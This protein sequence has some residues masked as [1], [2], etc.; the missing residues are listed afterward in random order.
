MLFQGEKESQP[1]AKRNIITQTAVVFHLDIYNF[2]CSLLAATSP[3]GVW[4]CS[5]E[6]NTGQIRLL[7][8]Y[9]HHA[10]SCHKSTFHVNATLFVTKN[11]HHYFR[12]DRSY[13]RYS[14]LARELL[15]I[16]TEWHVP[17]NWVLFPLIGNA[18]FSLYWQGKKIILMSYLNKEY[19]CIAFL[20]V[21]IS[22]RG[23]KNMT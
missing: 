3:G 20:K 23:D 14:K 10:A 12:G 7:R 1:K 4:S 18:S 17:Y 6:V 22:K 16:P 15:I 8:Q 19:T 11:F 2:L 13:S 21:F 9:R 5:K